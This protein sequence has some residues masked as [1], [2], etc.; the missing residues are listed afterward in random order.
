M[1]YRKT[2]NRFAVRFQSNSFS[3]CEEVCCAISVHLGS[4]YIKMPTTKEDAPKAVEEFEKSFVFL[5]VLE[6]HM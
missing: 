1:R 2:A 3:H 4:K 6:L 5:S